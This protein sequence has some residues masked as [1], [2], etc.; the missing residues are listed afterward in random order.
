METPVAASTR[1]PWEVLETE[2]AGWWIDPEVPALVRF[3]ETLGNTSR[4]DLA[5]MG[6]R[7]RSLI[8]REFTWPAIGDRFVEVY[9]ELLPD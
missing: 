1:S 8:E 6:K 5:S 2:Q 9:R 4:Q 7:G 3:L